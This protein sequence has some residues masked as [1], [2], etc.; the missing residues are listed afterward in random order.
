MPETGEPDGDR[1]E[2]ARPIAFPPPGLLRLLLVETVEP[3]EMVGCDDTGDGEPCGATVSTDE[4]AD[5]GRR[6]AS[7]RE[8]FMGGKAD[9][10]CGDSPEAPASPALGKVRFL[11][12]DDRW[13]VECNP[14]A[15]NIPGLADGILTL[16]AGLADVLN[17]RPD[18]L[19]AH[20]ECDAHGA[21][22]RVDRKDPRERRDWGGLACRWFCAWWCRH[23]GR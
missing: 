9:D 12:G 6:V 8:H 4:T 21:G 11:D 1:V 16:H 15:D 14:S 7:H 17:I 19:L 13:T 10:R 20:E 22:A 3:W 5:G 23:K 18:E 2:H